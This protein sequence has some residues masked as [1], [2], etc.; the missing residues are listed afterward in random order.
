M[1]RHAFSQ[2]ISKENLLELIVGDEL[3]S[4]DDGIASN[5]WT[6]ASPQAAN[7]ISGD[8]LTVAVEASFVG[9]RLSLHDFNALRL[10]FYLDKISR[11]CEGNSK[12]AC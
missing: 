7:S 4:V 10:K 12:T 2:A 11:I 6:P 1:K 5:I 9:G 8:D 3:G